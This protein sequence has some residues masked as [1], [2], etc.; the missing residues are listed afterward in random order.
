MRAFVKH[1][2]RKT[3]SRGTPFFL[4]S[5]YIKVRPTTM[6]AKQQHAERIWEENPNAEIY[7][8]KHDRIQEPWKVDRLQKI[9]KKIVTRVL[10]FDESTNDF[11]IR[12]TLLQDADILEFQRGHPRLYYVLTDRNVI[13]QE[14]YAKLVNKMLLLRQSMDGSPP[15][16]RVDAMATNL[17][18]SSLMNS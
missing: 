9:F 7:E 4:N 12:K 3:S 10:E 11:V 13:T 8:V 2:I 16:E 5:F 15:D 6:D 1:T 18:V 17:I 14:K